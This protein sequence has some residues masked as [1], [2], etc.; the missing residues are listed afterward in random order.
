MESCLLTAPCTWR[1]AAVRH[2]L[3]VL[4]PYSDENGGPLQI[5]HISFVEGR[6]NIIVTYPGTGT[7]MHADSS[8]HRLQTKAASALHCMARVLTAAAWTC[9]SQMYGL[10]T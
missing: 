8:M 3:D 2:V 4:N 5:Q 9:I 1:L 6:G 10:N 7:C